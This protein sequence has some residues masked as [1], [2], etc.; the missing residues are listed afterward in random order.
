LRELEW[1]LQS[2]K[3]VNEYGAPVPVTAKR[4]E[5]TPDDFVELLRLQERIGRADDNE[6]LGSWNAIKASEAAR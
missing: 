1:N 2:A 5:F 4:P 3:T 6:I